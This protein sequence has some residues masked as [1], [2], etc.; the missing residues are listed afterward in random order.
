MMACSKAKSTGASFLG[1][2]TIGARAREAFKAVAVL[3]L[4]ALDS[5]SHYI[6]VRVRVDEQESDQCPRQFSRSPCCVQ[7]RSAAG[8]ACRACPEEA[9]RGTA[10]STECNQRRMAHN[11]FRQ[12]GQGFHRPEP[13]IFVLP[14]LFNI[15][16]SVHMFSLVESAF[17]KISHPR[18]AVRAIVTVPGFRLH[19]T[20]DYATVVLPLPGISN[21]LEVVRLL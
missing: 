4:L 15:M 14:A 8:A 13:V 6:H 12:D 19:R 18:L 2:K 21:D 10:H 20:T 11:V 1:K 9:E 7:C 5:S 16:S 17:A 3:K